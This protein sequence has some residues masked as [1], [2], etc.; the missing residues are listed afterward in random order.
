VL[1][2]HPR[3]ATGVPGSNLV[4]AWGGEPLM[5]EA[6]AVALEGGLA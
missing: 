2:G 6:A 4:C 3:L 1:F 5:Q